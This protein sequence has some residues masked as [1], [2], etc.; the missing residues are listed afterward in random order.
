MNGNLSSTNSL[1][2][3]LLFEGNFYCLKVTR[4]LSRGPG[5]PGGLQG[6]AGRRSGRT[7]ATA[8]ARE[9]R[10]GRPR[11]GNKLPAT[12]R[13][14]RAAGNFFPHR[15]PCAP[16]ARGAR[17]VPRGVY[18]HGRLPMDV[19]PRIA[20]INFAIAYTLISYP[21]RVMAV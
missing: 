14:A 21:I 19:A 16:A 17:R 5:R 18:E 13:F 4:V 3:Q 12:A 15:L 20:S 2:V 8:A 9:A 6:P 10:R 1:K 7:R 11:G